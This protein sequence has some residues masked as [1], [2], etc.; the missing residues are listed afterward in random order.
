VTYSYGCTAKDSI[1]IVVFNGPA[2]VNLGAD[3]SHCGPLTI[4]AGN[5]G[6]TYTWSDAST[7]Q[8]LLVST[9]GTYHVGVDNGC[10]IVKDTVVLTI[11]PIPA[12][13]LGADISQCGGSVNLDAGNS[14][15]SYAWSNAATTQTI[16]ANATGTYSVMVTNAQNC[17]AKD[18]IVVS[19]QSVPVLELGADVDQCG[20]TVNFDVT[21]PGATYLWHDASTQPTKTISSTTGSLKVKVTVSNSCATVKDS[22]N[23]TIKSVP[24]VTLS[25]TPA[26]IC[27]H[28]TN[29]NLTGGSPSGGIYSGAGVSANIFNALTA[30]VGSQTITYTYTDINNCSASAQATLHVSA[31]TSTLPANAANTEAEIQLSPNPTTGK[32]NLSYSYLHNSKIE[33]FTLQG[34][35]V[36]FHVPEKQEASYA[37]DLSGIPEGMY[38]VRIQ[39][40]AISDTRKLIIQK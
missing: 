21:N 3:R 8:T 38:L 36:A 20:G 4:D 9:S 14:G 11:N 32:F 6:S 28:I 29:H 16:T 2:T 1:T 7:S 23:L 35:R 25:L 39:R 33:I 26:S 30:G 19:I 17:Q 27:D 13:N 37:I 15:S 34:E 18:T 10:G 31:C 22:M 40:G 5:P 24:S 12:V